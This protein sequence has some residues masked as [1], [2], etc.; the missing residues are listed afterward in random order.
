MYFLREGDWKLI[1]G[2][3]GVWDQWYPEPTFNE[4]F[5]DDY[6]RHSSSLR[7]YKVQHGT[8]L[9]NI[10]DDPLERNNLAEIRKDVVQKM[11]EKLNALKKNAVYPL[12]PPTLLPD[13]KASPKNWHD[14]WSPGWC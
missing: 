4:K 9:F 7:G 5:L 12:N 2:C 6:K 3:P 10:T 8:F 14:T 13:P 11:I 1:E